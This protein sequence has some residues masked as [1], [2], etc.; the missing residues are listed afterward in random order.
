MDANLLDPIGSSQPPRDPSYAPIDFHGVSLWLISE[1]NFLNIIF[2]TCCLSL[3]GLLQGSDCNPED[4]GSNVLRNVG[5]YLMNYFE[6]Y[7]RIQHSL[8][9][10]HFP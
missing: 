3:A 1:S 6:S 2:S 4:G 8:N 5:E 9:D 10:F 7:Q